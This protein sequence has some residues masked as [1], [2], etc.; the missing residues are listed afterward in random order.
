MS[1]I[2]LHRVLREQLVGDI[3]NSLLTEGNDSHSKDCVMVS[4]YHPSWDKIIGSVDDED[5]VDGNDGKTKDPHV[6]ILYGLDPKTLENEDYKEAIF[7]YFRQ[8]SPF[9]INTTGISC[10]ENEDCDVLKFDIELTDELSDA[11]EFLKSFPFESKFLEYLP[12]CTI[13]YLKKGMGEKYCKKLRHSFTLL[14]TQ[15]TYSEADDN[16]HVIEINQ[17]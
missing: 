9:L 5:C 15:V 10:F 16:R 7:T 11:N 12:H 1:I 14:A 8:L 17:L 2:H 13:A 4:L 6:T 3:V